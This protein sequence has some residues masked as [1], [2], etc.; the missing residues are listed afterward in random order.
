MNEGLKLED[1]SS[2]SSFELDVLQK[3]KITS[4]AVK[5]ERLITDVTTCV[6]LNKTFFLSI[7]EMQL[8]GKGG[9]FSS[10][11]A[12]LLLNC[13]KMKLLGTIYLQNDVADI[14]YFG[15]RELNCNVHGN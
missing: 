13:L 6:F 12:Q 8:C 5:K 4:M 2:V 9:I 3:R 1:C 10:P 7:M 15:L 11:M 14:G